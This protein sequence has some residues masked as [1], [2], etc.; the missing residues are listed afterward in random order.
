MTFIVYVLMS[1]SLNFEGVMKFYEP[2]TYPIE[3][4]CEIMKTKM[5]NFM[6]SDSIIGSTSVCIKVIAT[7]RKGQ[8]I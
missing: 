7:P 5:L 6:K 2:T 4:E 1:M 8:A 3:S